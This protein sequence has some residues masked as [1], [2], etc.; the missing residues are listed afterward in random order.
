MHCLFNGRN[1]LFAQLSMFVCFQEEG[2]KA[3]SL[4]GGRRGDDGKEAKA[5]AGVGRVL[6]GAERDRVWGGGCLTIADCWSGPWAQLFP[7]ILQ[8]RNPYLGRRRERAWLLQSDELAACSIKLCRAGGSEA[9]S[10]SH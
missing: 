6:L 10:A 4:A 8:R 5:R 3:Q 1:G 9:Q 7:D 2:R